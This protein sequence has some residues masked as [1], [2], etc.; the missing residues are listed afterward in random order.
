LALELESRVLAAFLGWKGRHAERV[1]R[2]REDVL[3]KTGVVAGWEREVGKL[4][5]VSFGG[6]LEDMC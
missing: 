6:G 3:A 5:G 2:G 4:H 1:K